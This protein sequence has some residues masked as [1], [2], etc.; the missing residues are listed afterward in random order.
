MVFP[1]ILHIMR[2]FLWRTSWHDSIM[3][4]LTILCLIQ[5]RSDKSL[6]SGQTKL[7]AWSIPFSPSTPAVDSL[8]LTDIRHTHHQSR[9]NMSLH[10]AR[11]VLFFTALLLYSH[12]LLLTLHLFSRHQLIQYNVL[13]FLYF[14]PFSDQQLG[15]SLI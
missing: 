12:N 10:R 2:R 13:L 9:Q 7:M 3:C 1:H 8:T 14:C 15:R 5:W 6:P 11:C 4:Q